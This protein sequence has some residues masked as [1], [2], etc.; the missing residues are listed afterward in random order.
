MP[1]KRPEHALSPEQRR[2]GAASLLALAVRRLAKRPGAC[3]D[4]GPTGEHRFA[5]DSPRDEAED[6]DAQHSAL[7]RTVRARTG[8]QADA[9]QDRDGTSEGQVRWRPPCTR[10]R[11][12]ACNSENDQATIRSHQTSQVAGVSEAIRRPSLSMMRPFES[13][14]SMPSL[15][16]SRARGWMRCRPRRR[17]VSFSSSS[18]GKLN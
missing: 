9:G 18:R 17:A 2:H 11:R 15:T 7:V 1:I 6:D 5:S 12:R 14:N 3:M 4:H 8:Q 13:A 16:S 10:I